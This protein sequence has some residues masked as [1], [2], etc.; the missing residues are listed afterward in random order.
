MLIITLLILSAMF[1]ALTQIIL[2]RAPW[3]WL[4]EWVFSW[5]WRY[6]ST[7]DAYH[8]YQGAWEVLSW[9]GWALLALEWV[10]RGENGT[11]A[12]LVGI[13]IWF[14]YYVVFNLFYHIIF[15]KPEFWRWPA[16]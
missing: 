7:I 5:D 3:S 11:E 13:V 4:P 10:K 15:T 9:A 6:W 12:I 2:F 14:L 1:R 16:G 8:V